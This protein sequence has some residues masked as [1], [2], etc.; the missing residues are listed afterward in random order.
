MFG[1]GIRENLFAMRGAAFPLRASLGAMFVLTIVATSTA[2]G[3]SL[4]AQP[5]ATAGI[6]RIEIT[7]VESPA[8]EGRSF[9]N[10][11]QY[12]KL[13]GR[14][15]GEVDP[16]D[17]RTAGIVYLDRA[18]R[19]AD[20]KVEYTT[21]FYILKPIDLQRGNR[22][23]LYE[24]VNRGRK[25]MLASNTSAVGFGVG[26]G[27]G[28]D[29][30]T[31]AD[32]GDGF[33]MSS[34]YTLAWSGWEGGLSTSGDLLTIQLPTPT[35]P[36]GT[37]IRR[38]ITTEIA[39]NAAAYSAPLDGYPAVTD[40]MDAA[41][42]FRRHDIDGL[43][44]EI[45]RDQWSFATCPDGRD[46]MP[47][48]MSVC[49]TAGFSTDW[50]YE[51]VYEARNAQVM[52][53]GFAA[54]R[55]IVTLLRSDTS[56]SNPLVGHAN[57]GAP[58]KVID[59]AMAFGW[60]QSARFLRDFLYQGFN[61]DLTGRP[62]FDG[63]MVHGGAGRRTFTNYP[64]G[65]PGRNSVTGS[66]GQYAAA[67][68]D[69]FPFT[70]E[71]L[72]DAIAGRSDGLLLR[73]RGT[74]TCPKV[75]QTDSGAEM[76][77][78]HA[79]LV[80]TTPDGLSDAP[81]PP[82]VRLYFFP[83]T[84]HAPGA[85]A[86]AGSCQQATNPNSYLETQRALLVALRGWVAEGREP[87]ATRYPSLADG[88]LV[89]PWPQEP[90]GFPNIPGVR[91]TGGALG[92]AL[93]DSFIQPPTPIANSDYPVY[94]PKVDRDGNDIAGIRSSMLQ[95]PLG[96]YTGW[97]LRTAGFR[98]DQSCGPPPMGSFIPF[99]IHAADR[100]GDPRLSLEERYGSQTGYVD[101]VRQAAANLQQDGFLLTEDESRLVQEAQQREIGLP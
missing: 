87:P 39:L 51:V 59:R 34:G 38:W 12:E 32:A 26:S 56:A 27:G 81:V 42:L 95:A 70:Y 7:R 11:G 62:V 49:Y 10:V 45:P 85:G 99:A 21:N 22:T 80:R 86:T 50:L 83:S 3:S 8:F 72:T 78:G 67:A 79:A 40:S 68:V 89:A 82:N 28:D 46:G 17:P 9:G 23:L 69:Q 33:L 66:G 60:S 100:A 25:Y 91:Y 76:W 64:F 75:M 52:G 20:G 94:V 53:L 44:E 15:Y 29:P 2:L 41:K 43:R 6:T 48:D 88:T 71:T 1:S 57:S 77:N 13:V 30:K 98:E 24:V 65:V 84:Q 19:N 14:A 18:P 61:E 16:T 5:A 93:V 96:T 36:D 55:D 97:N 73:C 37:Q 101:K 31:A 63:L 47:S 58:N 92:V 74:N 90:Q 35:N 4:P 54:T